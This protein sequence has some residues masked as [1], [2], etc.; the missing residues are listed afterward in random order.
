M[1]LASSEPKKSAAFDA[2]LK[3]LEDTSAKI[4]KE[5]YTEVKTWNKFA[6]WCS[7]T[8]S[9]KT[10]AIAT[11]EAAIQSLTAGIAQS[12]SE[13]EIAESDITALE[14]DISDLGEQKKAAA[15]A[16]K[17]ELASYSENN[18]DVQDAIAGLDKALEEMKAKKSASLLQQGSFSRTVRAAAVLASSL[19]LKAGKA[20]DVDT[21]E[22]FSY[23]GILDMLEELQKNFRDSKNEADLKEAKAVS[24]YNLAV[25]ARENMLKDKKQELDEKKALV[26][27][28]ATSMAQA[29]RQL[30]EAE[31]ML[32]DDET[33]L[34][35]TKDMCGA[36]NQTFQQRQAMREEEAA[37]LLQA[38]SILEETANGTAADTSGPVL[39]EIA[40]IRVRDPEI[41]AEAAAEAVELESSEKPRI[42]LIEKE[43]K[44]KPGNLRR[45]GLS[46]AVADD[47]QSKK[48][49]DIAALLSKTAEK[50]H[51]SRIAEL[52]TKVRTDPL[53]TIKDMISKM[54]AKLQSQAS[55]SQTQKA[56]CDKE[57]GEAE[58][59][60]DTSSAKVTKD[61][62]AL[63][64]TTARRDKLAEELVAIN[65]TLVS[66]N[67]KENESTEIRAEEANESAEAISEAKAAVQGV[68][69]ALQVISGF[70]SKA[71]DV[72]LLGQPSKDAPESEDD[73]YAGDQAGSKGIIGMLEVLRDNFKRTITETKSQEEEAADEHRKL[74][75][76]ISVSRAENTE[77]KRVK[78]Q[79]KLDAED[80]I[81]QL[82]TSL[83]QAT[84]SMKSALVQLS[85]LETECGIGAN[86]DKRKAA[87][88]EEIE[89][90]KA[91]IKIFDDLFASS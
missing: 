2:I 51:S 37:A 22:D 42:A 73:A 20:L 1:V 41:L 44:S 87:R 17:T 66:L 40:E 89:D 70:Y 48:R 53:K 39:V 45:Q 29:K 4:E 58:T 80:E 65:L 72:A 11:G 24:A 78:I 49:E 76:E 47:E 74:L 75:E 46:P 6:T 7:E 67:K 77:A 38:V 88:A 84:A 50:L 57:I 23:Q 8:K 43:V 52:V 61:N 62:T 26:A 36:K 86:Y 60:R 9:E 19:G 28:T 35:E 21:D 16:R 27:S 18:K 32:T 63:S 54:I 90:L 85:S 31:K 64:A 30:S 82:D 25:Q 33:Y 56:F 5:N 79:F 71:K 59:K 69:S 15:K 81:S 3:L 14:G 13:T 34:N 83:E 68:E 55:E 91:V 12:K 10:E